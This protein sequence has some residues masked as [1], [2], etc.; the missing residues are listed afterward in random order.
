M[1]KVSPIFQDA[2]FGP[3]VTQAMAVA[4]DK[5][6]QSVKAHPQEI[7]LKDAI[8]KRIIELA[9]QGEHDP[10]RLSE[11]ALKALNITHNRQRDGKS[12][13]ESKEDAALQR[14]GPL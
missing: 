2:A 3:E 4:F 12:C 6:C 14:W 13:S 11:L 7:L 8:A 10:V 5:A 1:A 9:R